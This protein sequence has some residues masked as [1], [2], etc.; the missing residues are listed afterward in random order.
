MSSDKPAWMSENNRE[1]R[2][3]RRRILYL[4]ENVLCTIIRGS[5]SSQAELVDLSP[6]GAAIVNR[7][8]KYL[9]ALEVGDRVILEFKKNEPICVV[10][11][12]VANTGKMVI[13]GQEHI[14][15]GIQFNIQIHTYYNEFTTALP[16]QLLLCQSYIRP[17]LYCYDSFFFQEMVLFQV[18]GFT[19]AGIDVVVS[20]RWKSIIPGQRLALYAH[21]PGRGNFQIYC[22]NSLHYYHSPWRDR[23]RIFLEYEQASRDYLMAVS[24]YLLMMNHKV[25]PRLLREA[26]F[27]VGPF[28]NACHLEKT[29]FSTEAYPSDRFTSSNIAMPHIEPI[30]T[31]NLPISRQVCCKLGCHKIAYFCLVFIEPG[32]LY[33][34]DSLPKE[35]SDTRSIWL[36]NFL[37]SSDA[38]ISD[39][40][41]PMMKHIIRITVQS[42]SH[43]LYLEVKSTKMIKILKLLGFT[44][45]PSKQ[46]KFQLMALDIR[47]IFSKREMQIG[48]DAWNKI[49]KELSLFL[50][51]K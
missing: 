5:E 24:E 2:G 34:G 48:S 47:R 33:F 41:V 25:T 32:E 15:I 36:T 23:F 42:E 4:G 35:S 18:N 8:G 30:D 29:S 22:K 11:G 17:Q 12:L 19:H 38:K 3:E 27:A 10:H 7:K 50:E 20:S 26:Q 44:S 14:R 37:V 49:Y 43:Y 39:F 16:G 21:I 51:E 45:K 40:L 31:R 6:K 28:E 46:R 9:L 13:Q 1:D